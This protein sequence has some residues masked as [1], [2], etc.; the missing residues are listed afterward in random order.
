MLTSAESGVNYVYVQL[1]EGVTGAD[2]LTFEIVRHYE[3]GESPTTGFVLE[4]DVAQSVTFPSGSYDP[5][6]LT[7]TPEATGDYR[8]IEVGGNPE[9]HYTVYSSYKYNDAGEVEGDTVTADS[10]T[11][12]VHLE[13]S[14]TYYF[15]VDNI[16]WT[17]INVKIETY[18]AKPGELGNPIDAPNTGET[19]NTVDIKFGENVYFKH[20]VTA[21]SLNDDGDFVLE[22]NPHP[23]SL[24]SKFFKDAECS[25]SYG[26][27]LGWDSGLYSI[28]I[29]NLKVNDVVYFYIN[30]SETSATFY[31]NRPAAEVEE[32]EVGKTVT[33]THVDG[34]GDAMSVTFGISSVQPGKYVVQ[35]SVDKD[36]QITK[37]QIFADIS[38]RTYAS[39]IRYDND[40]DSN[41]DGSHNR[42]PLATNGKIEIEIQEGDKYI[43]LRTDGG[44]PDTYVWSFTLKEYKPE[45]T[46]EDSLVVDIS[47]SSATVALGVPA[48][49]YSLAYDF[50]MSVFSA[51]IAVNVGGKEYTISTPFNGG[52]TG[53]V[54]IEVAEGVEEMSLT[55]NNN[56]GATSLTLSLT[57]LAP[58][59]PE[60][61]ELTLGEPLSVQLTPE[62]YII[63]K[64]IAL[65]AGITAGEYTLTIVAS[66]LGDGIYPFKLSAHLSLATTHIIR[67]PET[68][69]LPLRL[70]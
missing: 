11:G 49:N 65:G 22:F 38:G 68:T 3:A 8:L 42:L 70:T 30:A 2:K 64:H 13:E 36:P 28:T 31:I 56:G 14:K 69:R 32:M 15:C 25:D 7:F 10:K 29:N 24:E 66:G 34:G 55:I 50:G 39:K 12:A 44:T 21:D 41:P 6:W 46:L 43:T 23:G 61:D 16:Y 57:A 19:P 62:K 1:K 35:Y 5:M 60:E 54:D 33:H 52:Q 58:V 47:G 59:E 63:D 51:M 9:F 40:S 53:T 17:T 18:A 48:G 4:L 26:T 45:L 20:T 27:T 67:L 37:G